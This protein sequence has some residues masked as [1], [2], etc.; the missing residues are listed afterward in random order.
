MAVFDLIIRNASVI[1]GTGTPARA[2]D[3]GVLRGRV[4]AVG[5]L[6]GAE[7]LEILDAAGKVLCPGF[8]DAHVH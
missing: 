5:A 1:D 4:E 6:D 3:V 7:A 2:T 8:I